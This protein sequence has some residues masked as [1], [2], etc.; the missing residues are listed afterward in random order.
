MEA[1]FLLPEAQWEPK[2]KGSR[3]VA[4]GISAGGSYRCPKRCKDPKGS[5][6]SFA[7]DCLEVSNHIPEGRTNRKLRNS[8]TLQ[9]S[10][11]HATLTLCGWTGLC[12]CSCLLSADNS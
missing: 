4:E 3:V 6:G 8:V 12:F 11:L 5:L 1:Q 9:P 2:G 7:G 10:P